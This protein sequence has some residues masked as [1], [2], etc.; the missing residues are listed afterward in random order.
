[1][2][3]YDQLHRKPTPNQNKRSNKIISI[4]DEKLLLLEKFKQNS[5]IEFW[6]FEI[7]IIFF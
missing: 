1:M 7:W 6:I 4:I 2:S 3:N 5:K